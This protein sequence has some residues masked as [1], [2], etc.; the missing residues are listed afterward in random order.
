MPDMVMPRGGGMG[1]A[2]PGDAE[3]CRRRNGDCQ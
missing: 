1:R 3:A 2:E